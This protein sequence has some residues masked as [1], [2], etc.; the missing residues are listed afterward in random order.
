MRDIQ[1]VYNGVDI[2]PEISLAKCLHET[3]A[4]GKA[5]S[6]RFS[7]NDKR[8][9]WDRWN[10]RQGDTIGRNWL[11][12]VLTVKSFSKANN[13][14]RYSMALIAQ[15]RSKRWEV[16]PKK[17]PRLKGL[18]HHIKCKPAPAATRRAVQ[19]QPSAPLNHKAFHLPAKLPPSPVSKYTMKLNHGRHWL[20]ESER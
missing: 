10:P 12:L 11:G 17:L 20:I 3:M 7:F 2:C 4:N 6:L 16:S 13:N 5:D 18:T 9:L 8:R 19:A 1:L 14:R 15:W